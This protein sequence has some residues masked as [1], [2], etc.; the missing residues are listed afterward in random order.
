ME[1]IDEELRG[2]ERVRG[3]VVELDMMRSECK[4]KAEELKRTVPSLYNKPR[5]TAYKNCRS[6]V[7]KIDS[8]TQRLGP[9]ERHC[10]AIQDATSKYHAE[11]MD[12]LNHWIGTIWGQVYR[13][14][15]IHTIYFDYTVHGDLKKKNDYVYALK[16]RRQEGHEGVEMRGRCSNGQ[17]MLASIVV[18]LG[19]ANT[20]KVP[21]TILTLDEPTVNLDPETIRSLAKELGDLIRSMSDHIQVVVVTHEAEFVRMLSDMSE[22][23]FQVARN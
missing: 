11:L 21:N 20:F 15:D 6:E 12:E 3:R 22:N 7:L 5:M 10:K 23:Y 19:L 8:F 4:A 17:K 18:R 14:H 1:R 2:L 13:G 16:M 9:L